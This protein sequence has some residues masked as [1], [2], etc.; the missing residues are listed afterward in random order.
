MVVRG[1]LGASFAIYP[2]GVGVEAARISRIQEVWVKQKF[3]SKNEG[4][5]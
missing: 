5:D 2:G 4:S 3:V 1:C